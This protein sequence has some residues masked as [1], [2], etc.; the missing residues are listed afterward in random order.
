MNAQP[1]VFAITMACL[2]EL[3]E[4][5]AWNF[6]QEAF[7]AFPDKQYCVLTLPHDSPEPPLVSSFTRLDP[8]PGNSFPEVLYLINRHAL[9]EGFEVRRAEEADAEGVSMLVSGMPNSAH[10]QDLFR[11]AQARGTAVVASVQGEVVG[12]ATVS[13]SVDLVM[14]KANFSLSHLVNLPDQMSS[15][16][17]E[18]DMVC[19][20]P[21]FAHRARELL[22]GVHRILKKTVLYYAL[23]P[24][25]AIP[26]TLDVMQQVPPRHVDPPA[27]LEAE[28]A[29]YM[30]SRKS[31]FLKRQC[32]NAQVVVVGASETGLA[33]VE[34]MLLHPRLHL[35]FITLLA[36]GGIQMGD[37]ASQ[38]TKSIIAR[39]GLQARV[40]VLNA[41]M[42]GLDR[43]ERV[44]A[45]NDGAQL[46][47]DFLL[48]TC[49]LQEPTASFFAQR[50]PEVAGNVCGTQELTSDFMFG[51]SLTMERIVLYGSTLDAIQAWSVLE[52]RGGMSRLYSFCAPPAPPDP[53]VQVLQAAAEKLH[54]ELP[55]PQ[56]A[57]LRALE[58]TDEN[59]A[60]P[61]ASFEE[62][63]PVADSHVDLVIGCQQKQ[64]PTSIFTA[65]N[66]SG[67]VFDGR[68]VVDCAMCSSDPNIYAA[69]S[70]A[71]LSRRYGD[72]VLLQG[73]NARALGTALGESVLVRCTSIAQ[74]EGDTAELPNV[75]S[76]LQSFPS[77]V[78]G[79]QVPS[80]IANTFMFSGCPRAHQSP[81]LQPPAGGRALVTISERGF[82]QLTLDAGGTL[83]SAVL[84]GQVPIGTHKMAALAGLH[85]SYYNDLVA[86]FDAGEVP[87]L[88]HYITNE[89]WASLMHHDEFPQ[90]RQQLALGSMQ[91]LAGGAT[92]ADILAAAARASYHFISHHH[93]DFPRLM[94]YST[95][96]V[97]SEQAAEQFGREQ[98][99]ALS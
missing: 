45:L 42:V 51:D 5:Q 56:P 40:S 53:M 49:G 23:P 69:G 55:E 27:E 3:Y 10:V 80:P 18:I 29:L 35:N 17:A 62:G 11:N 65:L 66:D 67:V 99:A 84:L 70:C 39:L 75:L 90:L 38:Y 86:K 54:I 8:L 52:L 43:A 46:N 7:D 95:K 48:I 83:Y 6:L 50:D 92:P 25:Q 41:E 32:V 30:F 74:H 21:I 87:C 16:H 34:R 37:L 13:T 19:L 28:F 82:M 60:K 36:P 78:I 9:I 81:S 63:S 68:I 20:N 47:Y 85:V 72:N 97:R 77:K 91:E 96:T 14:L 89:P 2:D 64:V 57:R 73:Y 26:D 22:S 76:I 44:I 12:L 93:L 79:C 58:F 61:M 71:K 94:A 1:S 4:P 15:E 24:G 31:A 33:A 59:D 98:T 88:I